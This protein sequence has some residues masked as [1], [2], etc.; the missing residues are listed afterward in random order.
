MASPARIALVTGANDGIGL[1]VAKQLAQ[2]GIKV[3]VGAR[4]AEKGNP[5]V[6]VLL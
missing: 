2:Q 3:Y 4:T 5:A 1:E 6:Y